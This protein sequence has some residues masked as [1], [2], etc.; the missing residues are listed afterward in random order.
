MRSILLVL[1]LAACGEK[2]VEDTAPQ[3]PQPSELAPVS[4]GTCPD[5][6]VSGLVSWQSGG[7]ERWTSVRRPETL[8]EGAPIV[9]FFHGF[10]TPSATPQIS[11][12][13][14][15]ALDLQ[16]MADDL[17]AIVLVPESRTYMQFGMTFFMWNVWEE[18]DLDL[19]LYDD[20]RTCAVE[21]GGDVRQLHIM[22]FSGGS[23]FVTTLYRERNETLASAMEFSGG[24][25]IDVALYD[26]PLSRYAT[27]TNPVPI[28][29]ASGGEMDEW[30]EGLPMVDFQAA[31]DTMQGHLVEDGIFMVRCQHDAGHT[32]TQSEM[33]LME[34]W[35]FVHA[36]GEPSPFEASM[37]FGDWC[38]AP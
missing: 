29:L 27:P 1:G 25:D 11:E 22:G 36:Y 17:G 33:G 32:I 16:A 15:D 19:V 28:L 21:A 5:L 6:S 8:G 3:V 23:L 31:T 38:S 18:D 37:D 7:E 26:N 14:A 2:A 20:L 10:S 34:E 13:F 12:Y 35:P 24:S 30:P 4:S 9:F